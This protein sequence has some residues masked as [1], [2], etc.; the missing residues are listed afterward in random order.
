GG[1]STEFI[2]GENTVPLMME[3]LFMG[4]I[5]YRQRFFPEGRVDKK[6][7][8]AA[9]VA[10]AR[11][12]ET[13]AADYRRLGWHEAVGSSGS[14]QEIADILDANGLNPAGMSGISREGLGKL[15]Q[16]LIQAG[17]AEALGLQG[18]RNDRVA[19]LPGVLAIMCAV[20][21]ELEIEHMTYTDGALP[22][23]VLY[24]LLGRFEHHDTRDQTVVQFVRRYQADEEQI[25]R[26]ERTALTLLGQLIQLDAPENENDA[27]FLRWATS[28][29]EI[30]VSVAHN[31]AHKHGAYILTHA[32]MPGFSKRDQARLALLVLGQR[33][34]LQKLAA[35]PV[36]DPN[37]RLV[38]CLRLAVL[39]HRSREDQPWPN[40]LV[41]EMPVGF[42]IDLPEEWLDA[43]PMTAAAL[44]DETMRWRR[45]G[46]RLRVKALA[47]Q[48]PTAVEPARKPI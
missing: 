36:G 13:I 20:F 12:I 37:W 27:H 8:Q 40:L 35:M 2:I 38:F 15:R 5:S 46:I 25:I 10:A 18:M 43:N 45:V 26:V 4:C 1:G 29:H 16:L 41:R 42:Q 9:E 24:D 11:E 14:A 47:D 33:G 22:L 39:L 31:E 23:G 48:P 21:S 6:R 7:M 3:S 28:L 19:I 17:S 44:D 30:G 34:K 32:D